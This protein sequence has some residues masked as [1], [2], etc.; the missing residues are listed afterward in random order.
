M[1]ENG[2]LLAQIIEKAIREESELSLV[3]RKQESKLAK[4]SVPTWKNLQSLAVRIKHLES[5]QE[6]FINWFKSQ[7]KPFMKLN[8]NERDVEHM[9][10]KELHA[11]RHKLIGRIVKD[12][13]R[14]TDVRRYEV[15]EHTINRI[16]QTR[17]HAKHCMAQ[18]P[19]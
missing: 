11:E 16:E 14:L 15:I 18:L 1:S 17:T 6:T 2:D 12:E 10:L 5:E 19:A 4:E 7:P 9:T 3:S 8:K 13:P